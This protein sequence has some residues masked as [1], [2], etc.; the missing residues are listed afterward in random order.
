MIPECLSLWSIDG[1]H[2]GF[3]LLAPNAEQSAGECVF[4]LSPVSAAGIGSL[5]GLIVSGLRT[6]G[7][8]RFEASRTGSGH[9]IAVLPAGLPVVELHLDPEF[10]GPIMTDVEGM[11]TRV[12]TADAAS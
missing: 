9:I 7:E 11:P 6:R 1:D 12:G 3:L 4:M 2:A 5:L 10:K 8:H